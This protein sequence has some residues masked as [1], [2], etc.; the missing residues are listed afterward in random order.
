MLEAQLD[1]N[2]TESRRDGETEKGKEVIIKRERIKK[3]HSGS[4]RETEKEGMI[5]KVS[6]R[7][8]N[9]RKGS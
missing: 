9:G 8:G 3:K 2:Q 5:L 6:E 4:E 1:I 7:D